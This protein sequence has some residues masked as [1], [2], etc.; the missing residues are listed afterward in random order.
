V[1]RRLQGACLRIRLLD[2]DDDGDGDQ[3]TAY[4]RTDFG[5]GIRVAI[6]VQ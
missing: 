2:Y 6:R 1:L 4:R 5:N 3:G